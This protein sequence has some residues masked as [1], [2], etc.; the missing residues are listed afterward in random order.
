[1]RVGIVAQR[2]NDAAV[3][4]AADV[5][6]ALPAAVAARVDPETAAQLDRDGLAIDEFDDVELVVSIGGDGTFLFAARHA[7]TTPVIGVNL[8]EVGFLNAVAPTEAVSTVNR[9]VGEYRESGAVETAALPRLVANGVGESVSPAINEIVVQSPQRGRGYGVDVTVTVD[10]DEYVATHADGV[11]VAT[12]AGSSAYNLSEGGPLVTP[13]ATVLVVTVMSPDTPTR[14]L[15]VDRDATV[16]IEVAD[17]DVGVVLSDGRDVTEFGLP[18]TV[19]VETAPN[20]A[21]VAGPGV[22][23]FEAL[24]K[25]D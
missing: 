5:A 8:G 3:S 9:V 1:M 13:D 4:L 6:A 10:G 7:G 21:R 12:P 19:S 14:P 23:F 22:E 16:A 20:P 25:L 17:A 24:D 15:V 11:L 18:A 2:G